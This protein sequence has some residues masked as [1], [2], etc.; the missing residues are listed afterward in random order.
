MSRVD[1][2]GEQSFFFPSVC[3]PVSEDYHFF[4]GDIFHLLIMLFHTLFAH[5]YNHHS[6]PSIKLFPSLFLQGFWGLVGQS[7]KCWS[8]NSGYGV[9]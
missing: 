5:S 9:C 6:P 3:S 1:M 7:R 8:W 2:L 4:F